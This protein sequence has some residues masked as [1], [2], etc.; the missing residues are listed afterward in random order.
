MAKKR[1]MVK[2]LAITKLA[3]DET[4]L[5]RDRKKCHLFALWTLRRIRSSI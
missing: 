1:E 2:K 4:I 5:K 3:V